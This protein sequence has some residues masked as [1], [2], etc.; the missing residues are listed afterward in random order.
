MTAMKTHPRQMLGRVAIAALL[1]TAV[2][3]CGSGLDRSDLLLSGPMLGYSTPREVLV[4]VQ[5]RRPASVQIRYWPETKPGFAKTTARLRTSP[6]QDHIARFPISDLEPATRYKYRI[7]IEGRELRPPHPLRFRTQAAWQYRT[8]PPDFSIAIGSCAYINESAFDRPGEP[9]GGDFV[10]FD[11]ILRQLPDAM[12]WLGDNVYLREADYTSPK[13]IRRRFAHTRSAL[14]LRRLLSNVHNYAIWDDHDYGPDN[15]DRT[16]V[17]KDHSLK[18]FQLYWGNPSYGMPGVP[19]VFGSFAW[20]DAEFFLLD[21]RTYRSP[22]HAPPGPDK[23]LLGE[24]QLQW[25]IDSLTSSRARFKVVAA[26]GQFLN[27]VDRFETYSR[28]AHE[29]QRFLDALTER[30]IDGVVL[31]S[32]DR[33]FSELTRLERSGSYPLYEFTSSP[34]TAGAGGPSAAE[35]EN[36]LRVDGTVVRERSFGILSFSGAPEERTLKMTAFDSQGEELWTHSVRASDLRTP[37]DE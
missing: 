2:K 13:L 31:I 14:E 1:L 27:P 25:L 18:A 30:K 35:E 9:Y 15:S 22:N 11:N 33:H 36:P 29:K 20:G 19:G 17:F 10:I 32:G 7:R 6:S 12:I 24:A 28:F 26:G 23:R 34:L 4:W 5:T 8:D 21:N 3:G 16:F 37:D